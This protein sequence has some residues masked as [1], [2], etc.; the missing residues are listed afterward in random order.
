[1]ELKYFTFLREQHIVGKQ[2]DEIRSQP[3][4]MILLN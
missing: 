2:A 1:M 4:H 3:F